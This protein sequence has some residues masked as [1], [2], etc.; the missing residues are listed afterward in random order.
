[1]GQEVG[2]DSESLRDLP[3]VRVSVEDLTPAAVASGL[4]PD[5]LRQVVE[6]KLR[7]AG[8]P[9]LTTGDFPVGDPFLRVRVNTASEL[10]GAIESRGLIA[11]TVDVDFVQ[12]VFMR[13]NP[14]VTFN[15]AQTWQA[16]GRLGLTGPGQLADSV[17]RALSAQVDQFIG[18]Y[19]AVNPR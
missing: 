11:Y 17:M 14:A 1:V 10:R 9:V 5:R 2:Q 3:G 8:I 12:M 18:E 6:Q 13:R 7:Q 19:S 4:A 16:P 15:R